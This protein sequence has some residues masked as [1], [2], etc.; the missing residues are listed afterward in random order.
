MKL[1][2]KVSKKSSVGR[3]SIALLKQ[4]PRSIKRLK[5]CPKDFSKTPP[6]IANSFPKSG[7]HLLVQILEAFPGTVNYGSFIASMPSIT[8]RESSPQIHRKMIK[9]IVPGEVLM[10]HMFYDSSYQAEMEKRKCCH[11]FIYR[12]PRDVV[13]SEA[14]Y[15]TYMNRWHRLHR[16]F[17]ALRTPEERV[18]FAITGSLDLKFPYDYPDVGRRFKRYE[19]WLKDDNVF[20]VK[21]EDL[22]SERRNEIIRDIVSFYKK[23]SNTDST[24]KDI[25]KRAGNNIDPNK[26]HTFRKGE[27]GGWRKEF[28]KKHKDAFK[29]VAGDL[30]IR[31]GYEQNLDW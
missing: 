10:A 9:H 17:K 29:K 11:F 31:L 22:V 15:L 25:I 16:F 2:Y 28:E 13:V 20:A 23:Q 5:S 18:M 7:T 21:F 24:E 6:L 4:L 27:S 30:L 14:Y 12:D 8:Y 19:G 3:K 26:S 1:W